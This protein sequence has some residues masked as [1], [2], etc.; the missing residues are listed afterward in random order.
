[1][2]SMNGE[3]VVHKESLLSVLRD[4]EL[5]RR[6]ADLASMM[7]VMAKA[8]ES[9]SL[10][11]RSAVREEIK[12]AAADIASVTQQTLVFLQHFCGPL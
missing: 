10:V 6:D 8:L 4:A 1:M 5:E 9:T 3:F 12:A 7:E 2:L 11:I